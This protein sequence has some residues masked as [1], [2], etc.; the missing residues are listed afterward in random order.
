MCYHSDQG[1][2]AT[3]IPNGNQ[4]RKKTGSSKSMKRGRFELSN[5]NEQIITSGAWLNDE[6]IDLFHSILKE[7]TSYEPCSSLLL[8][9]PELIRPANEKKCDI[10]IL[11]SM[12]NDDFM[13]NVCP[14]G[15]WVCCYYDAINIYIYTIL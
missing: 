10:Q 12:S 3:N 14:G 15:H 13:Q 1:N 9:K 2:N 8:Q 5:E 4:K 6:H 7:K 11:F